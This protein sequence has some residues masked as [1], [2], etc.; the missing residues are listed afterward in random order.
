VKGLLVMADV[1]FT[2]THDLQRLGTLAAPHYPE[3]DAALVAI[4]TLTAWNFV[5]RYPDL[6]EP[7][8]PSRD[9]V[10]QA[11]RP[12]GALLAALANISRDDAIDQAPA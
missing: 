4:R 7:T 11:M 5:Y 2:E 8:E 3:Y 9:G 10:E 6:D 1:P 12:I